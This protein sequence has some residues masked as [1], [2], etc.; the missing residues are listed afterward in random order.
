MTK[1]QIQ[2][3][4]AERIYSEHVNR[5][6]THELSNIFDQNSKPGM[7]HG[8]VATYWIMVGERNMSPGIVRKRIR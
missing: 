8:N 3:I 1:W 7:V 2:G 5:N 4:V 6:D